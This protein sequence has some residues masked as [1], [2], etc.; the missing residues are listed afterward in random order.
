MSGHLIHVGFPKTG[1]NYLRRWFAAH[2]QLAYAEG[3]IAGFHNVYALAHPDMAARYRVTSF[4]GLT[5]PEPATEMARPQADVCVA[6]AGLFPNARVLM[7]TRGYRSMLMSSYSQY[8][9]SGGD[10]DFAAFCRSVAASDNPWHYDRVAGNYEDAFGAANV[11]VMP[12]E[13]L[14]D[15]VGAFT[16]ELASRLGI[17]PAPAAADRVNVSLSA[18]EMTWYP[19]L[20]RV[21]SRFPRKVRSAY[22]RAVF[23]NRLAGPIRMM[24]RL[25][26]LAPV[27]PDAIPLQLLATLGL[28][29]ARIRTYPLYAPYV[30][31]YGGVPAS[32]RR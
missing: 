13:L 32:E 24:Q 2:P 27:T 12:Y 11:I 18:L 6:L 23:T 10:E 16:R 1:T 31:D 15:D 7:L 5:A 25:K 9:R 17:D 14:R 3:G 28:G 29:A 30:E 22:T 19:R 8:I 26:P 20:G 21:A 4:E